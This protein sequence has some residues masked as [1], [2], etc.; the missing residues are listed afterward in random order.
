MRFSISLT[1][2]GI[3]NVLMDRENRTAKVDP[4]MIPSVQDAVQQYESL[5]GTLT[6]FS[7][8]GIDPLESNAHLR[9]MRPLPTSYQLI[10]LPEQVSHAPTAGKGIQLRRT[11]YHTQYTLSQF[12]SY[13]V[14]HCNKSIRPWPSQPSAHSGEYY[15]WA[16]CPAYFYCRKYPTSTQNKVN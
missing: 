7:P 1:E 10:L 4:A 6:T 15:G 14:V 12:P 5:G 16:E 11:M 13:L 8:F 2:K 3:P 9:Q